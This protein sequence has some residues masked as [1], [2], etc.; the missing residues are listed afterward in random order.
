MCF[1]CTNKLNAWNIS[2]G[3]KFAT[4]K[5]QPKMLASSKRPSDQQVDINKG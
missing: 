4:E 2:T 3:D 1:G 5:V